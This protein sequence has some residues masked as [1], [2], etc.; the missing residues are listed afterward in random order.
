MSKDFKRY[1]FRLEAGRGVLKERR[2]RYRPPVLEVGRRY[3]IVPP[4]QDGT[5]WLTGRLSEIQG[6]QVTFDALAGNVYPFIKDQN[7][8]GTLSFLLRL[9][10]GLGLLE[11]DK[12]I[13]V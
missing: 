7:P 8:D 13:E 4:R 9:H 3:L 1:E 2:G 5:G 11:S 12:F 6:V 10:N